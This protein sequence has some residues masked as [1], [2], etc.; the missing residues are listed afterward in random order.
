MHV[1][2]ERDYSILVIGEVISDR[3]RVANDA[4][5]PW[6]S[7]PIQKRR[8]GGAANVARALGGWGVAVGLLCVRHGDATASHDLLNQFTVLVPRYDVI[9][10]SDFPMSSLHNLNRMIALAK[11][12]GKVIL[13]NPQ[14]NDF[15]PYAGAT[16]LTPG[17]ATLKNIVG[18]WS[19]EEELTN[20]IHKALTDHHVEGLMLNRRERGISFYSSQR[21]THFPQLIPDA[22]D[23]LIA[24]I[25]VMLASGISIPAAVESACLS[26]R[27]AMQYP[28]GAAFLLEGFTS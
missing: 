1:K 2:A 6:E 9:V 15:S 4:G 8:I 23:S 25:A 11:E 14:G 16:L 3:Q 20:K 18:S 7:E 13:I 24:A 21:A 10:L 17:I 27:G 5:R 22:G 19:D 28:E 26:A 12:L